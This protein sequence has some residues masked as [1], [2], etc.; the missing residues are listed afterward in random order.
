MRHVLEGDVIVR[1][2]DFGAYMFVVRKG[3]V[4]VTQDDIV[5]HYLTRGGFFGEICLVHPAERR[6]ATIIAVT[7][8]ELAALHRSDYH[9]IAAMF[10][11]FSNVLQRV[12]AAHVRLDEVRPD[13]MPTDVQFV[14]TPPANPDA[15]PDAKVKQLRQQ[16]DERTKEVRHMERGGN[17]RTFTDILGSHE[18]ATPTLGLDNSSSRNPRASTTSRR[19]QQ[20]RHT[21]PRPHLHSHSSS[22][23]D[24]PFDWDSSLGLHES[25]YA[26]EGRA[27]SAAGAAAGAGAGDTGGDETSGTGGA[28]AGDQQRVGVSTSPSSSRLVSGGHR[29]HMSHSVSFDLPTDSSV[30]PTETLGDEDNPDDAPLPPADT[31][32]GLMALEYAQSRRLAFD[33]AVAASAQATPRPAGPEE[34][35]A[36]GKP[37]LPA[38]QLG[39][40]AS[41]AKPDSG[42]AGLA[43]L[44]PPPL[45]TGGGGMPS[46]LRVP[47]YGMSFRPDGQ[48]V[49]SLPG[50]QTLPPLGGPPLAT[51]ALSLRG[52]RASGSTTTSNRIRLHDLGI[53]R[54]S[55]SQASTPSANAKRRRRASTGDFM[56]D[57]GRARRMSMMGAEPTPAAMPQRDSAAQQELVALMHAMRSEMT[58][59][60]VSVGS[61]HEKVAQLESSRLL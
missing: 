15:N 38:L 36:S 5:R 32:E 52:R 24:I 49:Y 33:T 20:S 42:V 14:Q 23:D 10:P 54:H 30:A 55:T 59:L 27:A 37:P 60:R 25:K 29:P 39:G 11:E 58:A 7:P 26:P 22:R 1:E 61:L 48:P 31:I 12:A 13:S 56:F 34:C 47:M 17:G 4:S 46:P 21:Q 53:R 57:V 50:M 3:V 8:C 45:V 19:S 35:G 18:R 51:P 6:T 28:A 41:E 2:G 40:G 44:R 9:D 43:P 16:A